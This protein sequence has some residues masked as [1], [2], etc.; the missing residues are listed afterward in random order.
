MH[1]IL[2]LLLSPAAQAAGLSAFQYTSFKELTAPAASA[3]LPVPALGAVRAL[4]AADV[5][6]DARFILQAGSSEL[7]GYA[8]DA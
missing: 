3:G 4:P 6:T 5:I 2:L 1:A 7:L 8:D